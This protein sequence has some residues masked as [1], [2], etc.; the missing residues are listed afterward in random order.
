MIN[1]IID[2]L[3]TTSI[4][5][6]IEYGDADLPD[7]PYNVVRSTRHPVCGTRITIFTHDTPGRQEYI[8]QYVRALKPLLHNVEIITALG[9]VNKLL[10]EESYNDIVINNDDGT[11]SMERQFMAPTAPYSL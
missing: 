7:A 9:S 1:A 6:N 2:I 3:N 4:T 11:I 5:N 10:V 8:R